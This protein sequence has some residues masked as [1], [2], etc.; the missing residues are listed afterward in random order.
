MALSYQDIRDGISSRID[1]DADDK[2]DKEMD[3][4]DVDTSQNIKPPATLSAFKALW[5]YVA[6]AMVE[7]IEAETDHVADVYNGSSLSISARDAM[8]LDTSRVVDSGFFSNPGE[9]ISI[10][11]PG[12]Y[13]IDA[14]AVV[15]N[16]NEAVAEASIALEI[17]R[18]SGFDEP[19]AA[20]ARHTLPFGEYTTLTLERNV[21]ELD[22]GDEVRLIGE[23]ISGNSGF[24]VPIH[25]ASLT[26]T[27]T[28]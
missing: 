12:R 28:L 6:K 21:F 8:V 15:T 17:D 2:Y 13:R 4:S 1:T 22:S 5:H 9:S 7:E 26:I 16:P 18:G 23:E 10:D 25:A 24:T 11:E 20:Y 3:L 27:G 14:S 19:D